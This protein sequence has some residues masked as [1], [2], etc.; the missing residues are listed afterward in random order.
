M[1]LA[2]QIASAI[3]LAQ[4][5]Q[6]N[7]LSRDVW[8]AYAAG[9]LDDDQT[10]ELAERI[11]ARRPK[12]SAPIGAKGFTAFPAK[13]SA[14]PG[15]GK[16]GSKAGP[17]FNDSPIAKPKPVR[18]PDR[19]ASIDRRREL[20]RQS[21]VPPEHVHA[22]TLSEHAAMTV[23][24]GEVQKHGVC[25]LFMDAIAALAGTCRTVV[26]NAMNK[27]RALGLLHREERRRRGQKS[28]TNLIRILRPA[29]RQWLNWIGRRKTGSTKDKDPKTGTGV[30]GER[31]G[32]G[33]GW[34]SGFG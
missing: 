3:E 30:V 8:K 34:A 11:E 16:A 12:P 23:I 18:S 21:P 7:D 29:W 19:Q 9:Q 13:G 14:G 24:V 32:G 1:S 31:S 33:F 2:T 28:L 6:L 22:F 26:R 25:S 27:A 20:A 4:F 5:H 15:R 10:Q 17:A